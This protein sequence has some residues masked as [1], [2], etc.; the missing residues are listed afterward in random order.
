MK[1]ERDHTGEF[2]IS[3]KGMQRWSIHHKDITDEEFQQAKEEYFAKPNHDDVINQLEK[4]LQ[5]TF[6]DTADTGTAMTKIV[7]YYYRRLQA[8]VKLYNSNWSMKEAFESKN[9][10]EYFVGKFIN[11][12]ELFSK[13][14]SNIDNISYAQMVDRVA[15]IGGAGVA[16]LPTNFHIQDGDK[17]IRKYLKPNDN[18][19]DPS[20]G[21][22]QRCLVA[23]RNRVNY[24][25]TDP[26]V[27]LVNK[28]QEMV[29][30]CDFCPTR[31][32]FGK[33]KSTV[34]LYPTGSEV[35]HEELIGKMDLC[36]TSP[37]YFFL[38]QYNVDNIACKADTPYADWIKLY[39]FP[40]IC[41]CFQ[42]L[43]PGGYFIFNLK[44]LK[45]YDMVEMWAKI[46]MFCGFEY[47]ET[48]VFR[49]NGTRPGANKGIDK[50]TG[51][52]KRTDS[53]EGQ[54]VFRKPLEGEKADPAKNAQFKVYN[55]NDV[56]DATDSED[57]E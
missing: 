15:G 20:C 24:F 4:I 11:K 19:Y 13:G 56:A 46:A 29:D 8:E 51:K 49:G 44:N 41:N 37:P 10:I 53:S 47:A 52:L 16:A 33:N 57:D 30:D 48:I 25:G 23:L 38:E 28:I 7:R 34:T 26:N 9:I 3:Y 36:Y 21:W 54:Y 14:D 39:A 31:A 1:K 18:W 32:R 22:G 12:K 35:T 50:K 5:G 27:P 55:P 2:L 6:L 45:G 17:V 40:T 42:Y 43:K